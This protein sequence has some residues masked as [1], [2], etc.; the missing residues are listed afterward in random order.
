MKKFTQLNKKHLK[1]ILENDSAL[2]SPDLIDVD[3]DPVVGQ[4]GSN[5]TEFFSKLFESRE[6]AHIYHLGAKGE[7]SYAL[8]EA[9]GHYYEEIVGLLDDTIE[10]WQGQWGLIDGYDIIDTSSTQTKEPVEYF[11]ELAE[12]IKHARK[13]IDG[14]DTHIHSL[15]DDIVCLIYKTIY[16]LKFLK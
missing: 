2:T 8:H 14:E 10:I 12:Y 15:I 13:C 7:G 3:R 16:K 9:L 6:M 11:T 4:S 5:V 1:R